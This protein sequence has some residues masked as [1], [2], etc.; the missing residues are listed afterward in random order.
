MSVGLCSGS[1]SAK[2]AAAPIS[3]IHAAAQM[4]RTPKRRFPLSAA[5]AD[6]RVEYGV[7]HVDDEVHDHEAHGHEKH[8]ALQ[9]DEVAGVDRADQK[10][11][12]AGQREDRLDD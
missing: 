5:M 11:T 4:N 7:E 6:P 10:S 9:D 2:I 3:T 12:K 1:R 8:D